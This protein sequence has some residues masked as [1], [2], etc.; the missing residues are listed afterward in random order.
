[1]SKKTKFKVGQKVWSIQ[2]GE[3]T[4]TCTDRKYS[5]GVAITYPVE[6]SDGTRYTAE[7]RWHEGDKHPSL[8]HEMPECFKPPEKKV[9]EWRWVFQAINRGI[10]VSGRYHT[11]KKEFVKANPL[12]TPLQKVKSTKRERK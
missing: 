8:F 1:M 2:A 4:I 11:S 7:G 6:T 12:S 3:D 5:A 9:Y 10:Y